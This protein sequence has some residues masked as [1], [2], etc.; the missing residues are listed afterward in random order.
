MSTE[1]PEKLLHDATVIARTDFGHG[2]FELQLECPE[3][4]ARMGPGQFVNVRVRDEPHPLLR[5][6]F[7][8]FD[9]LR[10]ARGRITGISLLV[11]TVG[12]GTALLG[13]LEAGAQLSLHGPLGRR[14][15]LP[16]NPAV[17]IVMVGGG[18]GLAPFLH[19]LREAGAGNTGADPVG[20]FVLL[21]G[22][23]SRRDLGFLKR[24]VGAGASV[25][26]A[27]ED[28]TVGVKGRVTLLLERELAARKGPCLVLTCGPWAMMAAVSNLCDKASVP[29]VASLESVMACGYG[30][31]NGCVT[32]V[33]DAA[34]PEGFR[35]AKTCV[36]GTVFDASNILWE[37]T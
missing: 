30:V 13:R 23:R 28:G 21:A 11:H 31:C 36:E 33:R 5:R 6:P 12:Q 1:A 20:R 10:D 35:Y 2:Y 27:T 16:E 17:Q 4:A 8:S 34:D 22:A 9:L 25:L 15:E 26:P 29:C 19:L 3:L 24:F 18:I 37:R 7:S 32:R 14:F